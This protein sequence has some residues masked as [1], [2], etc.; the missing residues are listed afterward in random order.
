MPYLPYTE[1]LVH[2][3]SQHWYQSSVKV[4]YIK[5]I[6]TRYGIFMCYPLFNATLIDLRYNQCSA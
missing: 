6:L 1:H 4:L 2:T 5:V 3:H